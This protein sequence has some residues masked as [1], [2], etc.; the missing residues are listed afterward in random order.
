MRKFM[1]FAIVCLLVVIDIQ[2]QT[3][4]QQGVTYRYNGKQQRT[5]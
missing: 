2:G 3:T 1:L 4:E 5:P